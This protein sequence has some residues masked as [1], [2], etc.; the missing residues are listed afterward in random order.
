MKRSTLVGTLVLLFAVSRWA[1][2]EP[3][4]SATSPTQAPAQAAQA[5]AQAQA[6]LGLPELPVTQYV[7][8]N[9]LTVMLSEDHSIPSVATQLVYLVGSGH[10]ETGRTGFAHLFEHLMFQGSK[11]FDYDYFTPFEPIGAQVNGNTNADRTVYYEV[12][13]S[14]Y[15][16]L[17]LWMESDR[18]RSL[19]P[20]L[21]QTKLDN[22]REVVK[23]ER[24]QRYE[25]T[26]YGMA[27]WHLDAALF[28]ETHPYHHS[29]IGSHED[30]SAAS[31]QEVKAFFERYYVPKNTGLVVVGDFN[32]ATIQ[33]LIE[34]YF[35]DIAPGTRAPTPTPVRPVLKESAHYIAQDAVQLPRVYFAWIT[36]ALFEDGDAELDL[37]S[38][39]LTQGKTSR[40]FN[41]LVY[42][43][44]LAK[45]VHAYQMSERLS[46]SYV[47][48]ATATPGTDLNRLADAIKAELEKALATEPSESELTRARND[49]KKGFYH[50]LESYE[51][52]ADLIGTYFLHKETGDFIQNDF[53]R[54]QAAT[55]A[56]VQA[57]GQK[58]LRDAKFVRLDFVPG[59]KS[60]AL[61]KQE[62]K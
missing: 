2:A 32:T 45:D 20:A 34:K 31:L 22:Q 35:G 51:S 10:E 38:N 60:A 39:V 23:N 41:S 36:P 33:E 49:F 14:Q 15:A 58:Y 19:L 21:N 50:R 12:V 17:S 29:T 4:T 5:P 7:L 25:T 3:P 46:G 42:D 8:K 47:I 44:K 11:H 27:F 30:L 55:A 6:A 48:Q 26:P 37:L 9:G 53:S 1:S 24:R 18:M 62:I 61:Q 56:G 16:E 54:Y 28:P 13:P 40:L 59:D 57:A 52:R 43:Q